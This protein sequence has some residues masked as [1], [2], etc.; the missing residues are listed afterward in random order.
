MDNRDENCRSLLRKHKKEHPQRLSQ[1]EAPDEEL[2]SNPPQQVEVAWGI[3]TYS[4]DIFN[5]FGTM[6]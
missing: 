2:Q 6:R 1:K 5:V 4:S 3:P